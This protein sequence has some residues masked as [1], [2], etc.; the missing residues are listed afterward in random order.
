MSNSK[1][2]SKYDEVHLALGHPGKFGMKWHNK[3]TLNANYTAEDAERERPVCEGCVFGGMK[4]HSTD[5]LREHRQNPTRPGQIFVM[6]AYTHKYKSFRGMFFA[7]IF[8]D[9]ATQMIY[10]I[11]TKNRSAPELIEQ[12]TKELDKHP[13]WAVNLDITQ[14]RFFRVDEEANYRSQ[15]F[16]SFLAER[17]YTIE[18]TPSRDKHAGGIAERTV[19]VLSEKTNVAMISSIPPVPQKYWELAMSY[20]AITMG[21]TSHLQ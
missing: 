15:E 17:F 13:E 11:Y 1:S 7:D 16:A 2:V 18:K 3:N 4:Q 5:H 6:D 12:M 14:R 10:T 8:R 9:L 21:L 20:A 19:G